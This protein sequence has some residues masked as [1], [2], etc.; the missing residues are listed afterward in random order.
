MSEEYRKAI[1]IVKFNTIAKLIPLLLIAIFGWFFITPADLSWT[2]RAFCSVILGE[3][4]LILIFAFVGAETA[5]NV[6]GEIKESSKNHSQG[7]ND[8]YFDS[9]DLYIFDSNDCSGNS[10]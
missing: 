5:L 3:M 7:N 8:K 2:C 9:C 10:W 1:M 6:S 4:S